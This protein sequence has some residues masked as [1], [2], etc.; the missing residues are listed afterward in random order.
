MAQS[1]RQLDTE[2]LEQPADLLFE[3]DALS[4][5]S[6]ATGQQ[7]S[8]LVALDALYVHAAVPAAAQQLCD[9]SC[10][11]LVGLVAHGRECRLDLAS[12]HADHLVTSKLQAVGQVLCERA[13]LETDFGNLNVE[14]VEEGNDVRNLGVCLA[15][16]KQLTFVIDDANVCGAQ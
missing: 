7:R 15:F 2:D 1:C 4:Q 6:L 9:T 8:H 5:H 3:I 12:F 13:G 10:I 16:C 11:V 14:L